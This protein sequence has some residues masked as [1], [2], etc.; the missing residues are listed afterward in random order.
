M[1]T[2]LNILDSH[3]KDLKKS[4][5]KRYTLAFVGLISFS[6]GICI[7]GLA[8]ISKYENSDWFMIGTL[9]LILINGGLGIMIKNKWGTF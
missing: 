1:I 3:Y 7:F 4:K 6:S 8:V 9:S 5:F 2:I